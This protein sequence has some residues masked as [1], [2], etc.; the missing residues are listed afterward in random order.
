MGQIATGS[1]FDN[2]GGTLLPISKAITPPPPPP[3][4]TDSEDTERDFDWKNGGSRFTL[5]GSPVS[6]VLELSC[7]IGMIWGWQGTYVRVGRRRHVLIIDWPALQMCLSGQQLG[8]THHCDNHDNSSLWT[9]TVGLTH[10]SYLIWYGAWDTLAN[11]IS[12]NNEIGLHNIT[13]WWAE[14]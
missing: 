11:N 1:D 7:G 8:I 14:K 10:L 6:A 12:R 4:A 9:F 2:A 5:C 13:I 3:E